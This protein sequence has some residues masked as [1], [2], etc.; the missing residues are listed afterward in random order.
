VSAP[1]HN[2]PPTGLHT[3][4]KRGLLIMKDTQA[5]AAREANKAAREAQEQE[6]HM[7]V[8]YC[9]AE[10]ATVDDELFRIFRDCVGPYEQC[11]IIY[12]R[13]PGLDMRFGLADEIVRSVL[14]RKKPGGK[15]H[16]SVRAWT[17]A[18][19]GHGKLLSVRRRIAHQPIYLSVNV[20]AEQDDACLTAQ[21]V[22]TG[23]EIFV[24]SHEQLRERSASLP[25]LNA[26]DLRKHL[27]E[28]RHLSSQLRRFFE[29]VLTKQPK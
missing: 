11:A 7:L 6:F 13:M 5:K 14:P 25:P 12:Y 21:T 18:I 17:T 27:E 9:I 8:G 1:A 16:A 24:S 28:V 2:L 19:R 4:F 3:S 22:Q 20:I 26:K 23:F 15:D 29:G 10:W